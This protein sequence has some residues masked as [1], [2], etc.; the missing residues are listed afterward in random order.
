MDCSIGDVVKFKLKSGEIN[1]GDVVFIERSLRENI[2]YIN[3]YDRRAYRAYRI[4]EKKIISQVRKRG[5][6][7]CDT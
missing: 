4:P 2:V 1:E 3:S 7:A 6:G 5:T